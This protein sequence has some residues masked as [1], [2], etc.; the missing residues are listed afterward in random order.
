[1]NKAVNDIED[2][3]FDRKKSQSTGA[4]RSQFVQSLKFETDNSSIKNN[5]IKSKAERG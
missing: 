3:I 5:S 4:S 2:I 1:M